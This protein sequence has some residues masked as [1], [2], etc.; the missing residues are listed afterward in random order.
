MKVDKEYYISITV[1]IEYATTFAINKNIEI[2]TINQIFDVATKFANWIHHKSSISEDKYQSGISA[3]A[4]INKAVNMSKFNSLEINT[5]KDVLDTAELIFN[6][7]MQYG[8][9]KQQSTDNKKIA[10]PNQFES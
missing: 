9:N 8:I 5:S 3:Q 6:K 1:A 2:K 10:T 7:I 4:S